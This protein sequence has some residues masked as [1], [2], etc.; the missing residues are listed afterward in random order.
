MGHKEE[1]FA[2]SKVNFGRGLLRVNVIARTHT[3]F[4]E[5][6]ANMKKSDNEY[7]RRNGKKLFPHSTERKHFTGQ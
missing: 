2:R 3:F 7:A 5:I 1:Q 4:G 6:I